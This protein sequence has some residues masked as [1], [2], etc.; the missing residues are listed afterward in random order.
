M[1]FKKYLAAVFGFILFQTSLVSTQTKSFDFRDL[2]EKN[3][4]KSNR[5]LTKICPVDTDS[6]A[7]RIFSEYGAIFV[8]NNGG[9]L[10]EKCIFETEEEVVAFQSK[11]KPQIEVL[12][13]VRIELQSPAMRA[14]IDARKDAAAEGLRITPRGTLAGK[15]SFQ[16]TLSLWNQ[17]FLPALNYW[18]AKRKI[19]RKDAEAVRKMVTTEQVAKVLEWEDRGMFFSKDFRKS[20]LHSVSAPGASQHIFMLA[21]DVQQFSDRR[22]RDILAKHG[23]YQTVKSDFPH[24]T[25]LG[26]K[27]NEL[28][29]LAMKTEFIGG[30]K[31]WVPNLEEKEKIAEVLQ[32][33]PE[34]K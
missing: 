16:Q 2:V 15:R 26:V 8:S 4:K 30:Y 19:S 18:V 9:I 6:T 14:L 34:K 23:W 11:A 22:V 20:I 21:L 1:K 24:F 5:V 29:L 13:G 10:P 12:D 33:L 3:L 28:P 7:R 25:Y 32:I 31:F 27:E 17:R